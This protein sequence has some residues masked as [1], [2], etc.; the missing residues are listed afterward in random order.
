MKKLAAACAAIAILSGATARAGVVVEQSE[1]VSGTR[2]P[3]SGSHQRTIMVEGNKEKVLMDGGRFMIVDLDKGTLSMVNGPTKT[4]FE[5]PFPPKGPQNQIIKQF[6]ADRFGYKKTGNTRT[7]AGYK[8]EEY[9]SSTK[10]ANSESST[11]SCFS[12]D[13]PGA[14]E[15]AAFQET[16]AAKLQQA[17]GE[18]VNEKGSLPAGIPLATKSSH[19]MTG[20]S[21]PGLSPEQAAKLSQMIANHPPMLSETTVT[22]ITTQTLPADAFSIPEGYTKRDMPRPG[23]GMGAMGGMRPGNVMG[24]PPLAAPQGGSGGAPLLP[25]LP[26]AGTLPH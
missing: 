4:Y 13:A 2:G 24:V 7:V 14:A 3:A 10:T 16:A 11:T 15:Y 6:I 17:T 21:M 20:F 26:N 12:S 18:T 19:K 23:P 5:S 9:S 25:S 8:C 22:K 1:T